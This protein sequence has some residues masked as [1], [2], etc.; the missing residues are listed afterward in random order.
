MY[1]HLLKTLLLGC[2]LTA[3]T[4]SNVQAASSNDIVERNIDNT[5]HS[6]FNNQLES[7]KNFKASDSKNLICNDD[8]K[9]YEQTKNNYYSEWYK[10]INYKLNNYDT[11]IT[12]DN[13]NI[14]NDTA[15]V[16]AKNDLTMVFDNAPNTKQQQLLKYKFVLK[17]INGQWKIQDVVEL[18]DEHN[19]NIERLSLAA[20]YDTKTNY[21]KL[22][23]QFSNVQADLNAKKNQDKID[24]EKSQELLNKSKNNMKN[25]SSSLYAETRGGISAAAYAQDW[26]RQGHDKNPNFYDYEYEGGD[27][28]NFVS[29]CLNYGGV[30][31][32]GYWWGNKNGASEYWRC[33]IPLY[34][35]L[36]NGG[37]GFESNKNICSRGDVLQFYN[38]NLGTWS[39]SAIVTTK[40]YTGV[41]YSAHSANAHDVNLNN[42]YPGKYS[43]CRVIGIRY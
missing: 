6:Y 23:E 2:T 15:S 13:L 29:Q 16:I 19:S 25:L 10:G 41:Y 42:V 4:F 39:H 34:N 32:T 35:W 12:Y 31:Q 18:N 38:S 27:C 21:K 20:N 3:L 14:N 30:S 33:V 28:T 8:L 7:I 17:N 22:K 43:N 26:T 37:V 40:D 5:I 1:K 9:E 11:Q 24:E 36:M